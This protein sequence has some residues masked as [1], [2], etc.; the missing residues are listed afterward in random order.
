MPRWDARLVE[1]GE[2]N[3]NT[4]TIMD[5]LADEMMDRGVIKRKAALLLS[6]FNAA[7]LSNEDADRF[8]DLV[9]DETVLLKNIRIHRTS[10]PS[11]DISKL[12]ISGPVT[13]LASENTAATATR[14]PTNTVVSY[15]TVKTVSCIDISGEVQEDTV[16]GSGAKA[17]IMNAMNKRIGTDMEHLSLE[18]DTSIA[19]GGTDD[20]ELLRSNDGFAVLT[21]ASSNATRVDVNGLKASYVLLSQM[22][23]SMPTAYKMDPSKLVFLMHPD[24]FQDLLDENA[25]RATAYGD[26]VRTSG[27]TGMA[28]QGV[29]ILAIPQIPIDLT[30]SGTTWNMG[31]FILLLDPMNLIY[32]IQRALTV[33]WERVPRSDT[34]QGTVHM[35]TDFII[36]NDEAIVKAFDVNADRTAT[37]YT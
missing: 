34:D 14:K 21:N 8:I 18:G 33:E 19:A 15:A 10:N 9:V 11:G 3:V 20:S 7:S 29:R 28:H 6:D 12:N 26:K 17:S 5:Q 16:A 13:R 23:R 30:I 22:L 27:D 36:E 25:A 1:G 24:C 35:R 4:D 2:R 31:T 37:A 32:V